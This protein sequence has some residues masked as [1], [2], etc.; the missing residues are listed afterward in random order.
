M[1]VLLALSAGFGEFPKVA[2]EL[3]LPGRM[4]YSGTTSST[5]DP[6]QKGWRYA[7]VSGA[8]MKLAGVDYGQKV[9]RVQCFDACGS[10]P[11]CAQAVCYD[12]GRSV[13]Q[14][15]SPCLCYPMN[16]ASYLDEDGIGGSN[17]G[18]FASIHCKSTPIV[19]HCAVGG[20]AMMT[21]KTL[22]KAGYTDVTNAGS[23]GR[24]E[25]LKG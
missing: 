13:W 2:P 24:V 7:H 17:T 22:K 10:D 8:E 25:K 11:A 18:G 14:D 3:E 23:I 6:F 9:T 20:E 4:T 21:I 5:C 16:T 1:L 15:D 19:C 12:A